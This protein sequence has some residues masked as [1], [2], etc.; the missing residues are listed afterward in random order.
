MAKFVAVVIASDS[1]VFFLFIQ[2]RFIFN[3]PLGSTASYLQLRLFTYCLIHI[4]SY[5][6]GN[7]GHA[8]SQGGRSPP[9]AFLLLLLIAT[10]K[11]RAKYK[12]LNEKH[13]DCTESTDV[14]IS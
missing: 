13:V 11:I 8:R 12:M 14:L 5:I 10:V 6:L 7:Y 3:V 4:I 9:C 1:L 2:K